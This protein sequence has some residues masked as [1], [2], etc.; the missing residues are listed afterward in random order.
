MKNGFGAAL[1]FGLRVN[2]HAVLKKFVDAL[3]STGLIVF[4]ESLASP[5]TILAHPATMSH[6]SLTP[7][8]RKQLGITDGFFRLSVGFEDPEDII[9]ALKTG[10]AVLEYNDQPQQTSKEYRVVS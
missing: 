5:E 2:D 1:S 8:R 6:R 10:F 9:G 3:Q 4:A 7:E